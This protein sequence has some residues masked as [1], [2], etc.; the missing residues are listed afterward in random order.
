ML[1]VGRE[2]GGEAMVPVSTAGSRT[3][4]VRVAPWG[5]SWSLLHS[6][7]CEVAGPQLFVILLRPAVESC[8]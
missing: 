4:R 1:P 7:Q 5:S 6:V 3:R 2:V 8:F